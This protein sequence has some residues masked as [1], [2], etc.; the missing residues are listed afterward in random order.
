MGLAV[1]LRIGSVLESVV[2]C[3][4]KR[5]IDCHWNLREALILTNSK[6]LIQK[7]ILQ[8]LVVLG[9]LVRIMRQLV[10]RW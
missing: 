2:V 7:V 6:L 3:L 9:C 10:W 4:V 8:A 1:P 5:Q